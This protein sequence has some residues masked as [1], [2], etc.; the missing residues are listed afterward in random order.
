MTFKKSWLLAILFPIVVILLIEGAY[1]LRR[2]FGLATVVLTVTPE[3]ESTGITF[4]WR[5]EAVAPLRPGKQHFPGAYGENDVVLM[6]PHLGHDIRLFGHINL[7]ARNP[8]SL[9]VSCEGNLD[10]IRCA[11]R[12]DGKSSRI[13]TTCSKHDALHPVW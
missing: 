3:L 12:D 2:L 9:E 5:T 13:T 8:V 4:G 1:R 7:N 11:F 6:C 10:E